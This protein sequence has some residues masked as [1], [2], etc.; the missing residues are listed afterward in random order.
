MSCWR[1]NLRPWMARL[2][3]I[4]HAAASASVGV[5]RKRLA[6]WSLLESMSARRMTRGGRAWWSMHDH[7]HE[8]VAG[9]VAA[10]NFLA[11]AGLVVANRDDDD[12]GRRLALHDR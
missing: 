6:S 9:C 8:G 10:V 11:R 3:R 7:R 1:R 12:Q 4:C 2:R 5:W